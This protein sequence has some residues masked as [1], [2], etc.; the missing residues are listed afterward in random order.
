M[1]PIFYVIAAVLVV[2]IVPSALVLMYPEPAEMPPQSHTVHPASSA[3]FVPKE[4]G[5]VI[6]FTV[7]VFRVET[8]KI[9]SVPLED[10]VAGV[11]SG[12]MPAEFEMEALKAQAL[13]A[14]TY[15]ALRLTKKDFHDVPKG[16]HVTDTIKHQVYMDDRQCKEAWGSSY[17][18]KKARIQQAVDETLGKV[19]TFQNEPINATFFST[20]NG[21]T[22]NSEEYWDNKIPYLRSVKVPWDTASPRYQESVTMTIA[23]LEKRLNTKI[24]QPAAAGSGTWQKVLSR[25]AGQR[26]KEIKIGDKTFSGREVRT[27]LGLNSSHFTMSIE[28]GNV[29]IRT[30]GYGHGVGMSQWGANGMAKEGKTAEEI[31]AYFYKGITIESGEKWIK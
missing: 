29:V 18:W 6:D 15:L 5:K 21:Y 19:L 26:V 17:A 7:R 27:R 10:Y 1:K 16:A 14:R 11:L 9:D 24:A 13:A 22:E 28:K 20:S 12:E 8:G 31:V 23:Q 25:T 3:A 30:F 2:L 4:K